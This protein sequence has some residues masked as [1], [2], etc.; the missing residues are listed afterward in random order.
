MGRRVLVARIQQADRELTLHEVRCRSLAERP[1]A[2]IA[3]HRVALVL[4][5]G[6]TLGLASGSP[7]CRRA[8]ARLMSVTLAVIKLQPRLLTRL[9]RM[10]GAG[11]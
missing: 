3:R 10:S 11:R 2:F 8:Y 7:A 4:G 9:V 6:F 1:L 5:G